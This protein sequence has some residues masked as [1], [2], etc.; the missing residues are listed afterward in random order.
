MTT[1]SRTLGTAAFLGW[2]EPGSP[3]WYAARRGRL[4]GSEIAAVLG[5]SPWQSRFS[6]WHLKAGN[7]A[8][9]PDNREMEWGRD[10]EALLAARFARQHHMDGWKL[11]RC[12]LHVNL[13]RPYQVAQPDRVI[14][15]GGRRYA[16]LE[17]KTARYADEWGPEGSDDIP[18]YYRCQAMWQMDCFGFARCHFAV[19]ITGTDY[20]EYLVDYDPD[21]AQLMR[22]AAVE[23]LD[24]IEAGTPPSIDEH[25]ATYRAVRELHPDIDDV[26]I[27]VSDDLAGWYRDA[28]YEA[29]AAEA[30]KRLATSRL[31]DVMGRARLAV[32]NGERIAV[33]VPSK[34]GPPHLRPAGRK[35]VPA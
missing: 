8:P 24:S 35:R 19:L 7:V 11:R 28:L 4:G 21:E 6:L 27:E 32:C 1:H 20:R 14:L 31:L 13:V 29:H 17:I 25:A 30:A 18:V 12:A 15:L 34:G 26:E 22:Q 10:L 33:R 2:Y 16:A 5:L 9:E 23:F 3:E